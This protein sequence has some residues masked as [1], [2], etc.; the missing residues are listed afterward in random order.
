[1]RVDPLAIAERYAAA[2]DADDEPALRACYAPDARI[3]HNTDGKTQT[4]EENLALGRWLHRKLPDV[5]FEDVRNIRTDI[6]FVRLCVLRG[7]APD[8]SSV[9][10]PSCVVAFVTEQGLIE[11]V[12]EYLD[13]APLA[14]VSRGA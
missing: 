12:D 9:A 14:A 6:G 5:R 13:P 11:R 7:H 1:M 2:I 3:W 8:G 10:V 4:V